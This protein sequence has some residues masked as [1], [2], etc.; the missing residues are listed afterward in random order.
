M[1]KVIVTHL[2]PPWETQI[3]EELQRVA[4]DLQLDISVAKED[5]EFQIT[6]NQ[7]EG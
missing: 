1:P 5:D 2:N 4:E 7:V 3:R 6:S